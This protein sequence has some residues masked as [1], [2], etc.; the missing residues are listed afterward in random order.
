MLKRVIQWLKRL[1]RGLFGSKQSPKP[2]KNLVEKT[3]PPLSDTDL[4]FLFTELLAGVH[5]AKGQVWA[6]NWLYKIEHRVSTQRWIEWLKHL[7]EKLLAS[8]KPNNELAARLVQLGEL[9]VGEVGDV[10][11]QIGMKLFR[12][13]Q[14]EPI[15]EYSGP[16]AVN[17]TVTEENFS[18]EEYQTVTWD[19]LL[20]MLQENEPLRQQIK[21]DFGIDSDDPQTI[22]QTLITKSQTINESASSE[23]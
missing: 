19:E 23:N 1:I 12:R 17:S 13:T 4:E 21:Q 16:D 2:V 20:V 6:Q 14:V 3:T 5:Q 9:G 11:Y 7:E 8:N 22:V 18:E 10:A 15:W